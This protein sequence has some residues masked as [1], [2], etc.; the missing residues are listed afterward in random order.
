M[1][2][3]AKKEA[4]EVV[5]DII[6]SS[7]NEVRIISEFEK[8][9]IEK[10]LDSMFKAG[11]KHYYTLAS[12]YYSQISD[13]DN[14][15]FCAEKAINNSAGD[16]ED[17]ANVVLSLSNVFRF[18]EIY[19]NIKE[20]K[21]KPFEH[22]MYMRNCIR[23]ITYHEDEVLLNEYMNFYLG[24]ASDE[25]MPD[26]FTNE[27]RSVFSFLKKTDSEDGK[28]SNYI[29]DSLDVFS[30][31]IM[32]RCN[33]MWGDHY[34]KYEIFEYNGNPFMGLTLSF[35]SADFS[36]EF[37]DEVA[38]VEDE[39]LYIISGLDCPPEYRG[40]VSFNIEVEELSQ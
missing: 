26:I 1:P 12:C 20:G 33:P 32:P 28:I 27:S 3:A 13:I 17:L 37:I 35:Q 21:V 31:E 19:K 36:I 40:A 9:R 14:L 29:L 6:N 2:V 11:D 22:D 4:Y 34:L 15:L 10:L 8:T 38:D 25:A 24:F 16:I 5:L 7:I 30:R 39:F 18:R 23:A